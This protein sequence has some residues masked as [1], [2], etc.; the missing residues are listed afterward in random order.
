MNMGTNTNKRIIYIIDSRIVLFVD[1]VLSANNSI[2]ILELFLFYN[3]L[4]KIMLTSIDS[5]HEVVFDFIL[6]NS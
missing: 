1:C 2:T 3:F 6:H 5:K 4:L